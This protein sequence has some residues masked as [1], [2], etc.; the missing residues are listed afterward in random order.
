MRRTR[1]NL[2]TIG[3]AKR[4]VRNKPTVHEG[5]SRCCLI[6]GG[7]LGMRLE[8]TRTRRHAVASAART[9][10]PHAAHTRHLEHHPRRRLR[11][12]R[13]HPRTAT[14]SR[15]MCRKTTCSGRS[16]DH[17]CLT[18]GE[19]TFP[20]PPGTPTCRRH[21]CPSVGRFDG[22]V[23]AGTGGERA[24]AGWSPANPRPSTVHSVLMA[25]LWRVVRG[26]ATRRSGGIRPA[27]AGVRGHRCARGPC[28]TARAAAT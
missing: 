9:D 18:E 23:V 12:G 28:R 6:V 14:T 26:S 13:P 11:P 27:A 25:A 16:P 22:L 24:F 10:R 8:G 2:S 19:G 21:G 20:R 1:W 5:R 3:W 17:G 15:C 4:P 7:W